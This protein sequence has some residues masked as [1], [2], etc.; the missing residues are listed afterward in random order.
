MGCMAGL[1]SGNMRVVSFWHAFW[2]WAFWIAST[3][4][5]LLL[6]LLFGLHSKAPV[7]PHKLGDL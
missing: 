3:L 7:Q 1:F 4:R 5:L 2:S 6:F